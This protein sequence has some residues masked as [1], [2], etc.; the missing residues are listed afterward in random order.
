MKN[1]FL[2]VVVLFLLM[3]FRSTTEAC[4]NFIVTKGASIDG[5]VMITYSADSYNMYGE[6]YHFKAAVYP[7]GAMLEIY[8]WDTGK[9]LGRIPQA[10][11]T[12]NVVGNINENQVSIGETT[13][14]GREEL[15]NEEGIID[16]GSLMYI[17]LQRSKSARGAIKIM[18]DLVAEYGYYSSGESFSIADKNEAWILEMIGKGKGVKGAVWV[19]RRIPDGYVSGHANQAR[20]TTFP[21]DDPDNCLYSS[22]VISFAREMGFYEGSDDN[23]DFAQVY[24]PL[25]FGGIRFCDGRV[26]S[27]FRRV[28]STMDK[29]LSYMKGE[30]LE[31]M[32]LWIK[33][34]KKLSVHDVMSLMRDHFEGTEFDMTKG[35]AAGPYGSPY[36]CS[37]LTF[38]VGDEEYF[39]ER[40]ISTYQTGFSFV[41]Q[42]RSHLPDEIG[43]VLWFGVDDTYMTVYTPMYCSITDVPHNYRKGIASFGQFSWESVFW[44]FN[45]VSNFVYPRYSLII[46][47]L[48]M[49]QNELEG[50]YLL[51]QNTVEQTAQ[52]MLKKSRGEAVDY[53][54][55]YS[56]NSGRHTYSTWNNFFQH[57]NMKYMDGV[58]KNEF[59][60]PKRIGY[61]EEFRKLI[62]D[63]SDYDIKLKVVETDS[64]VKFKKEIKNGDEFL[65]KKDYDSAKKCY[66]RALELKPDQAY[67][68]ERLEKIEKIIGLMDNLHNEHFSN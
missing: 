32:P 17:A 68:K 59:A 40:P 20:I 49:K 14:V 60:K 18:T 33:P 38:K 4:T 1:K 41:S 44:V 37:P 42:L 57:L 13:F 21:K 66:Q 23:F 65:V 27:I 24:N 12:Y 54:T 43:G 58:V 67:P 19:A 26:W 7:A 28:N 53:L 47:E 50:E 64:E 2:I 45:A 5:S 56:V 9:F 3:F 34:D 15:V 22:D 52:S 36:R 35:A 6:L 61:P 51:K 31:R 16:Y 63:L 11:V 46:D 62:V 10:E 29:Y 25:D 55:N 48:R 8:E 39:H 30:S